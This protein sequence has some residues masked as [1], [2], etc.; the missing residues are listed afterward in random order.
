MFQQQSTSA[1]GSPADFVES[2]KPTPG[3]WA[4][5]MARVRSWFEVPQGY[6]DESG[7]H[8][9]PQP[10]PRWQS[11]ALRDR[12]NEAMTYPMALP[13]LISEVPAPAP[14]TTEPPDTV[15]KA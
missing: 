6:E 11:A 12:A 4:R 10:P 15:T 2:A 5:C 7:F 14:Q 9:G 8:Y 1:T 3:V 13:K